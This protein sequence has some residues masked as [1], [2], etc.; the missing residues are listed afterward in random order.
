MPG[1]NYRKGVTLIEAVRMFDDEDVVEQMFIELVGLTS[2]LP[3]VWLNRHSRT[4]YS[5]APTV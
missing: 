5:K 4:S 2:S 3:K 1:K